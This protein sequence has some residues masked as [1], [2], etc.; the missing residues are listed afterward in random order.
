LFHF[1][2]VDGQTELRNQ[3][4]PIPIQGAE[5]HVQQVMLPGDMSET[6]DDQGG[7]VIAPIPRGV[8]VSSGCITVLVVGQNERD[9]VS[10]VDRVEDVLPSCHQV[11]P[12]VDV[13]VEVRSRS[14]HA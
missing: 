5:T 12:D 14:L 3:R 1:P 13:V 11:T 8:D 9:V 10:L 2:L 6:I 7:L 4:Y